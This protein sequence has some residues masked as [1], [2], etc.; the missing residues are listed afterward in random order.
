MIP[1][2]IHLNKRKKIAELY[3]EK[4]GKLLLAA[5]GMYNERECIEEIAARL[6]RQRNEDREKQKEMKNNAIRKMMIENRIDE[7]N[8]KP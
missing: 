1:H 8:Q 5:V 6:F 2:Q 3:Y 7:I 4:P